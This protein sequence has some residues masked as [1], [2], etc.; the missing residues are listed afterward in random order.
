[1]NKKLILPVMILLITLSCK[2]ERLD[3][4][5]RKDTQKEFNAADYAEN[6]WQTILL[7]NLQ[8]A[9]DAKLLIKEIEY[10]PAR[11]RK[12]YAHT[13]GNS[14]LYYYFIRGAGYIL[15]IE[16][17]MIRI[18]LNPDGIEPELAIMTSEI[19]GNAIRDGAGLLNINDFD[20][21]QNF[22]DISNEINKIVLEKVVPTF[23][24]KLKTG[25]KISFTGC[26]E[27]MDET[28]DLDPLLL[29]PVIVEKM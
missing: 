18:S 21:I 7:N 27:V 13:L 19:Y 10:N 9:M 5:R 1:M 14:S 25:D 26:A 15:S 28:L 2:I 23:K 16:E 22:N 8:K 29:V 24:N 4:A 3:E 6:F 17:D 12:K 20:N 11:A